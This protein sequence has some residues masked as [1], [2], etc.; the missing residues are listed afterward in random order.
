[1]DKGRS[2]FTRRALSAPPHSTY[3]HT[4]LLLLAAAAAPPHHHHHHRSPLS[5]CAPRKQQVSVRRVAAGTAAGDEA[6]FVRP[7]RCVEPIISIQWVV[8]VGRWAMALPG[9]SGW[10]GWA[11]VSSRASIGEM[12]DGVGEDTAECKKAACGGD[13]RWRCCLEVSEAFGLSSSSS[14][15]SSTV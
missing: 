7:L 10:T 2:F 15:F 8:L 6:L 5:A 9:R 14:S 3:T 11:V 13:I 4:L 1:M 12:V